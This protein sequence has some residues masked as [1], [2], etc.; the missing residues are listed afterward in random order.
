MNTITKFYDIGDTGVSVARVEGQGGSHLVG[1]IDASYQ[2]LVKAFGE[3][4]SEGDAYKVSAEWDLDL[5]YGGA[6]IS[7]TIYDYKTGRNYLGAE[8][9]D[10]EINRKWHIGAA[11]NDRKHAIDFIEMAFGY[12]ISVVQRH[13]RGR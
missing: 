8:G 13:D 4:M 9:V 11:G 3:H 6:A 7:V 12:K 1:I 2:D 10:Y 5:M